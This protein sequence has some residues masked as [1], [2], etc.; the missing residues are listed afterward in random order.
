MSVKIFVVIEGQ[1]DPVQI[2]PSYFATSDA[3]SSLNGGDF[4][5]DLREKF[6]DG[7]IKLKEIRVVPDEP[8]LVEWD[9]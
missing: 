1:P 9:D 3:A 5:S 7:G 2:G 4:D 8:E 6:P